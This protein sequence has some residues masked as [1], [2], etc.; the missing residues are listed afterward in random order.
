MLILPSYYYCI[1]YL[2]FICK[3][4]ERL[5]FILKNKRSREKNNQ[6]TVISF[7]PNKNIALQKIK[8]TRAL[9]RNKMTRASKWIIYL[10]NNLNNIKNE[11]KSISQFRLEELLNNSNNSNS[12]SELIRKNFNAARVNNP[13][14]MLL[15][16]L[17][18]IIGR[19][20]FIVLWGNV[21][22]CIAL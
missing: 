16:M 11:M 17:L 22:I 3:W 8:N 2:S 13:N 21:I 15:C 19:I 12:Q 14:W 5:N 7:S 20:N 18:Q 9:I 1:I 6:N 10:V 4:C